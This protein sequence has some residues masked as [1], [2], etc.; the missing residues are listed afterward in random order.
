MQFLNYNTITSSTAVVY[1]YYNATEV[2]DRSLSN[3]AP[4]CGNERS[5]YYLTN[6]QNIMKDL[7]RTQNSCIVYCFDLLMR[8]VQC[9]S[10]PHLF[11][12]DV[13]GVS[14]EFFI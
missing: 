12:Q 10:L 4:C 14:D 6:S 3:Q 2:R 5:T 9:I 7:N 8:E 1:F 11:R 13:I